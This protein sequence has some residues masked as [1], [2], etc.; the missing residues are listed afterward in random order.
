ML[1]T[2]HM[3]D[4]IIEIFKSADILMRN[5]AK[6]S[7]R[8][9]FI[10]RNSTVQKEML[11]NKIFITYRYIITKL[12]CIFKIGKR[13]FVD[14]RRNKTEIFQIALVARNHL[15]NKV[16]VFIQSDTVIFLNNNGSK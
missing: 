9:N 14:F 1:L 7:F 10:Y 11:A 4:D 6:V 5:I 16:F 13:N 3:S 8:A 15:I 2:I 12:L